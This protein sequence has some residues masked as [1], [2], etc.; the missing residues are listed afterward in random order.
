MRYG[1][2]C[3]LFMMAI[4]LSGC[5][6]LEAPPGPS[7]DRQ[8]VEITFSFDTE[9]YPWLLGTKYP[10]MAVWAVTDSEARTVFVTRGAARDDWYFADKRPSALPVW[11]GVREQDR[12]GAVDAVSGATPSGESHTIVWALPP[13]F[14]N[15]PVD[16]YIEANVSFDYNAFYHDDEDGTDGAYSDV[17]GQPSMVWKASFAADDTATDVEPAIIGHGHV[18]G[19][20]HEI[21]PDTSRITTADSL[22]HY[23]RVSYHPARR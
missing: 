18:L 7:V 21:D 14:T 10:Q 1:C 4:V 12:D 20:T 9:S 6:S 22:F 13:T 23:I 3:F 2:V 15:K 19:N 5:A 17:N 16:V 11:S 8:R